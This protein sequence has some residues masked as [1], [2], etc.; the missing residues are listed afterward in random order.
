[1]E[2]ELEKFLQDTVLCMSCPCRDDHKQSTKNLFPCALFDKPI[3]EMVGA[4]VCECQALKQPK[5]REE[6]LFFEI[7]KA[8]GSEACE[9]FLK[10]MKEFASKD[11]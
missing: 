10:K 7:F 1:M 6:K 9:N 8:A 3:E 4:S 11:K 5:I 2:S